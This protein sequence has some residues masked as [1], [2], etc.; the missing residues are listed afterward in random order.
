MSATIGNVAMQVLQYDG[1][2]ST[3]TFFFSIN[4]LF[5]HCKTW[6]GKQDPNAGCNSASLRESFQPP[7]FYLFLY[8][9]V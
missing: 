7:E 3:L 8:K 4:V 9:I 2:C 6:T 5:L 1:C